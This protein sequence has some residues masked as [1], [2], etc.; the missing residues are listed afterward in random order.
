[1]F[2]TKNKKSPSPGH[3]L[4][5]AQGTDGGYLRNTWG[6]NFEKLS[7]PKTGELFSRRR[8]RGYEKD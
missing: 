5:D 6:K 4:S 3:S 1:M 7:F 8:S 2:F